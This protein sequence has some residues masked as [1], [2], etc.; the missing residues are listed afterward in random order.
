MEILNKVISTLNLIE[1][2]GKDN[3]NHLLGC[4]IALEK[5]VDEMDR[6]QKSQAQMDQIPEADAE[7]AD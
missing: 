4:I 6:I 2:S 3:M 7:I 1:V 5:L